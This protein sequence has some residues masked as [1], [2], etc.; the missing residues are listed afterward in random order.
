MSGYVAAN[1][2]HNPS[3]YDQLVPHLNNFN[4][5]SATDGNASPIDE[6]KSHIL[7]SYMLPHNHEF[8][9]HPHHARF[10]CRFVLNCFN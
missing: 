7:T 5:T 4:L 8:E 6:F 1:A 2:I 10:Y 3:V 9:M